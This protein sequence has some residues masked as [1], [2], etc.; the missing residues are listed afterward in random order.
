MVWMEDMGPRSSETPMFQQVIANTHHF[1]NFHITEK[2]TR[3]IFGQNSYSRRNVPDK[4]R[5][6]SLFLFLL[7][8]SVDVKNH[9]FN[10][11]LLDQNSNR[12]QLENFE[13][14]QKLTLIELSN[15]NHNTLNIWRRTYSVFWPGIAWTHKT[16]KFDATNSFSLIDHFFPFFQ[17]WDRN[18][19]LYFCLLA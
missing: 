17:F 4:L 8:T 13:T 1:Q 3:C 12:K 9:R 16:I 19:G 6:N 11:G 10:Y 18:Y 14:K 2:L 15:G 7:S 5:Y